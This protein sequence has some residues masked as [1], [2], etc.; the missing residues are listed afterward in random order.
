MDPV[1]L[2]PF[3]AEPL[4]QLGDD[5]GKRLF[6]RVG[7]AAGA[8][9][10]CAH[11]AVFGLEREGAGELLLGAQVGQLDF[12]AEIQPSLASRADERGER[13]AE[14][15]VRFQFDV[16]ERHDLGQKRVGVGEPAQRVAEATLVSLVQRGEP[17][18][19]R[20]ERGVQP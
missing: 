7:L 15:V 19:G 14:Q 9:E 12:L 5:L 13:P 4:V 2:G 20:S 10:E 8:G 3:R 17:A 11:L 6:L 16:G 1:A 18:D